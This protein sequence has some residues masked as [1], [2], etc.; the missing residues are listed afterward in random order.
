MMPYNID[1]FLREYII[2]GF[3]ACKL[4]RDTI[5]KFRDLWGDSLS[6]GHVRF[7]QMFGRKKNWRD[8]VL[9]RSYSHSFL[10]LRDVDLNTLVG[11]GMMSLDSRSKKFLVAAMID[12]LFAS[13]LHTELDEEMDNIMVRG[14]SREQLEWEYAQEDLW[15]GHPPSDEMKYIRKTMLE[16]V[17]YGELL[18]NGT[19]EQING[20]VEQYKELL[21]SPCSDENRHKERVDIIEQYLAH[22]KKL[23]ITNTK[24]SPQFANMLCH[25]MPDD[26]KAVFNPA[27]LGRVLERESPYNIVV[28]MLT[29]EG[30]IDGFDRIIEGCDIIGLVSEFKNY[31]RNNR[32]IYY[33]VDKSS[34]V[35]VPVFG[36]RLYDFFETYGPTQITH[37]DT[38][39]ESLSQ[40]IA[41]GLLP[42]KPP[43]CFANLNEEEKIQRV[44]EHFNGSYANSHAY[45]SESITGHRHVDAEAV[46][47]P[48]ASDVRVEL[49]HTSF[50]VD[51]IQST[52]GH[53]CHDNDIVPV[54]RG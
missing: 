14:K 3:V 27:F 41:P 50:I 5:D 24:D 22:K 43:K 39:F 51:D 38:E 44:R 20:F 28:L 32:S 52:E 42:T 9:L 34:G 37:K 53:V 36:D 1:A 4:Y 30:T 26:I 13:I 40:V 48:N 19:K 11:I 46:V 21:V 15:K 54:L 10:C 47:S 49:N 2:D 45:I 25:S 7:K 17:D 12:A 35:C 16:N 31:C 29:R 18:Y 33:H 23:G 6:N 8:H